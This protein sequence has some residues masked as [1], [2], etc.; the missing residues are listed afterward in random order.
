VE[1]YAWSKSLGRSRKQADVVMF[2]KPIDQ[3]QAV[4]VLAATNSGI[5]DHEGYA[6]CHRSNT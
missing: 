6:H 1:R 4:A 5:M 2:G 3:F